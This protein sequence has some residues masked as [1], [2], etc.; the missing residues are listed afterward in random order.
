[1]QN[2]DLSKCKLTSEGLDYRGNISTTVSGR[3]CQRW[4]SQYPWTHTYTDLY[5]GNSVHENY[6]RNPKAGQDPTP[7]CYTSDKDVQWEL[8][9]I[10]VCECRDTPK[11]EAYIGKTSQTVDGRQCV[12]W[13]SVDEFDPDYYI[14]HFLTGSKSAHANYCRNPDN[15]IAPWCFTELVGGGWD[16]CNIPFCKKS[17]AECLS[18]PK[19]LDYF[20]TEKKTVDNIECQRWDKVEQ[21]QHGFSIGFM[22]LSAS[23]H[24]NYCRNPDGKEM[25]WCYPVNSTVEFQYCNIPNCPENDCKITERGL[26]YRGKRQTTR[27]GI[28]CQRWDSVTPHKPNPKISFPASSLSVQE[29]YCRNPDYE[30]GPWC[31]TM[32]PHVRW[33]LCE[34]PF[35]YNDSYSC[36]F[37]KENCTMEQ[38]NSKTMTWIIK[39]AEGKTT[40]ALTLAENLPSLQSVLPSLRLPK[41]RFQKP[42]SCLQMNYRSQGIRLSISTDKQNL[43]SLYGTDGWKLIK[44]NID[45][46]TDLYQITMTPIPITSSVYFSLKDIHIRN[47][48][49]EDCFACLDDGSCIENEKFC[50]MSMDC[51]DNSDEK[52]CAQ[53]C[54]IENNYVGFREKTKS[55]HQ[56]IEG[57]CKFDRQSKGKPGC[58]PNSK[59]KKEEWEECSVPK[60]KIESLNCDF[61]NS[62]C[63]WK[64]PKH[65]V[66]W[67]RQQS[68]NGD[69]IVIS[70]RL[71]TFQTKNAVLY[72]T[73]QP[74][75]SDFG[76]L[77]ISYLGHG[78][79]LQ[80][81]ITKGTVYT[82][83]EMVFER[84]DIDS[85][86]FA[87]KSIQTPT[88][89]PYMIILVGALKEN[90][91]GIIQIRKISYKEGICADKKPCS[92]T[93][94]QCED[95][96]C[97]PVDDFCNGLTNCPNQEDE[98][99]CKHNNNTSCVDYNSGC[100]KRC[101]AHCQCN[102][103]IF[104][105][106]SPE[107]VTKEVRVLDLSSNVFNLES[108]ENFELL[109][110]LNLSRC[111]IS[112]S[113][114]T[115]L[116]IRLNS[117]SLQTLDL[118]Y[119]NIQNVELKTF[120][121]LSK[122]LYLNISNNQ[123]LRLHLDF[124][125][126]IPNL[127]HLIVMNNSIE[128]IK[129]ME[130]YNRQNSDLE[131]LDLQ[132]NKLITVQPNS[133]HWLSS[134]SKI[135]LR[136][137]N[138]TNTDFYF[139][140]LMELLIELDLSYNLI[141]N[142]TNVMFKG[143]NRLRYLNLQNNLIAMLDEFSFSRLESLRTL[144]LAFNQIHTINKM[145]FENL[146][147][148][149][150]L[151]LTGNK[152]KSLAPAR[153]IALNK[154]EI[155]DLSG[156]GLQVLEYDAF[157]SSD[158]VKYLYI[159]SNK[160]TV[161]RAMFQGLCN[162]EWLQT[163]SYIICCAKPLTV[164]SSK[165]ISPKDSISSCE[166]LIN[167]GFLAQMIWYMALFSVIGNAY[168][169]YYRIQGGIK[170]NA[171]QG[172]FVL[173]L[174]VSDF[175]MGVYLFI[176]AIADLE[177][178]NIYGFNDGEWR[179]SM[180]C[181]IA[182]LLATTSSEASMIFIFLITIE[183]YI[184]LKHPFS[185]G[186]A[187]NRR[188]IL[189][190]TIV[191]WLIAI[192][193]SVIPVLVYP[194]F[195]SRS[196]VC[197]SL[198][199]TPERR[200]GWEYS[201][202]LF[203]GFNMFIFMAIVVG[204]LLI[205]IQVKR[206]GKKINND[207][208]KREMAVLKSLS[209]VVLSDTF[210]WIPIII[211]GLLASG[212][213]NISSDVYAWVIVLVLPINSALNPFIYT[214]SMIYRQKMRHRRSTS[215]TLTG[216]ANENQHSNG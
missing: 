20:G 198:P 104:K 29:N 184:V 26:G 97:I 41:L 196:T 153:F 132:N 172:V 68:E 210:C 62:M 119:N 109:V 15:K 195:Y 18:S 126:L 150:K 63:N 179:Y 91:S 131:L 176:I 1:M 7:W 78:V 70:A 6:C 106:S 154:L 99:P 206:M 13:D 139:S 149:A 177:Y 37:S 173:H 146:L 36:E 45:Y 185:A 93:Q 207:N 77:T 56:C 158:S 88:N 127:R 33:Q 122:L 46:S 147:S 83:D 85:K 152:L 208:S 28:Q 113:T 69:E 200:T 180:A 190:V 128:K 169:I 156:N 175:L 38:L 71:D 98:S 174:S 59:T 60:C 163:D 53:E 5:G 205:Y 51:L 165:C 81:Y 192:L 182:G 35:C 32:D 66:R 75:S 137:N 115:G 199:L 3:T 42:G 114:L 30:P 216:G 143:L 170:G 44:I 16:Y 167:V 215:I 84:R 23:E 151:N 87:R 2:I 107:N 90:R 89:T 212:G 189:F 130:S 160:L 148:L 54:Y 157:K 10:P 141:Q 142:I 188:L 136:N 133:L 27:D 213:V 82:R 48:P 49:C 92:F 118:S 12:R 186:F 183:R 39:E 52:N 65:G 193:F 19:G 17:N 79:H 58:F 123:I 159:H 164:H 145:A 8:C 129:G 211:I 116:G 110:H 22:G 161:S 134:V 105:C 112:D 144:N 11:G 80:L 197:I 50:D 101:P 64:F 168:V 194:D 187:K 74:A 55:L 31:Y 103:F 181:T 95:G 209:Y 108:L 178:R 4:D 86:L 155:L 140:E 34:V 135:F 96:S 57:R 214:F 204:Q 201:T 67:N 202:F 100:P 162:L 73:P 111:F 117:L 9:D 43:T 21:L 138:I 25:P 203:I 124:L 61:E 72:G 121:R 191:A 94:F 102:G 14:V 120:D 171:S 47:T 166:Q 76:C 40:L 24:E 125:T